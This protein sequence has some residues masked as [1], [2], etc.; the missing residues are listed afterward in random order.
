MYVGLYL[1]PVVV[2]DVGDPG[3]R[4]VWERTVDRWTGGPCNQVSVQ[5]S[6]SFYEIS[7]IFTWIDV[8][9]Q[10]QTD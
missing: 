1:C 9:S 5:Q 2:R 10:D 4:N 8:R 7:A 3:V 6:Q